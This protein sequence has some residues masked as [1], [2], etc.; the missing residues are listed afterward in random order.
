M[1]GT[2]GRRT[3]LFSAAW[4]AISVVA[5]AGP[6]TP[7]LSG[8]T[9]G[10]I[11]NSDDSNVLFS[12]SGKDTTPEKYKRVVFCILDLK[13]GVLAQ[14]VGL[15]DYV[16]YHTKVA[17]TFD[18]HT[19]EVAKLT[20][21]NEKND[22]WVR[23]RDSFLRLFELGTDPLALT[24][25]AC[26]ERGVP[27]V[28]SYRMNS[29]DFYGNTYLVCDF[30]RA[31][32]EYRIPGTGAL[33][34]AIPEVYEQR[35]KIFTEVTDDYDIDGIELDFRRW[36][37]MVSDP[38]ENHVVLT[39]MLRDTRKML[40]MAAERKR[41]SKLLL[42]VRVG[43]SL[44]S[45]P[46]P[47]RYPG[48]FG[49]DK[50]ADASCKQLGLDVKTWIDEGLVDYVCPA[51]FGASL[52]GMPL[53]FLAQGDNLIGLRAATGREATAVPILLEKPELDVDYRQKP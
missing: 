21:P 18:K 32:P 35:M 43:P 41:R 34:P 9:L 22:V 51:L 17:T 10:S 11:F 2:S 16:M 26:R 15:P 28:A 4:M 3:L 7:R 25:E 39:R 5:V 6:D 20:W 8:R 49:A 37:H 30:G 36:Y 38:L 47:F 40:D 45:E 27:I 33:D 48:T 46:T 12:L 52:P 13:P 53:T 44:E 31:H 50:A 19:V 1:G 29:E 42:G 23:A 24:I 14:N